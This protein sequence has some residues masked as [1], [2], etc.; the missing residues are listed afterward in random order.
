[1]KVNKIKKGSLISR[2]LSQKDKLKQKNKNLI[3]ENKKLN[4][5]FEELEKYI[6]EMPNNEYFGYLKQDLLDKLKELKEGK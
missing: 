4:N 6:K 1:M 5:T 2:L 3:K